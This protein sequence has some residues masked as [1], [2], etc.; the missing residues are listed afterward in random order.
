MGKPQRRLR[1]FDDADDGAG[2]RPS[3]HLEI[4]SETK[5][6]IFI[7]VVFAVAALSVLALFGQSGGFFVG[8][9]DLLGLLMGS[10]KF[11]F[12]IILA[13]WAYIMLRDDKYRIKAIN[14]FGAVLLVLGLT[15]MWHLKFGIWELFDRANEGLGGGWLG[16]VLS[17]P[18]LRYMNFWGGMVVALAVFLIGL[19]LS[20]EMSIHGLMWPVRF[21]KWIAATVKRYQAWAKERKEG[22]ELKQFEAAQDEGEEV[23]EEEFDPALAEAEVEDEA[24]EED[25]GEEADEPVFM[26][27]AL[28][29]AAA[30]PAEQAEEIY[31]P[32]K[33]GK[34]IVLPVNLV[35]AKAGKPTSGD[36]KNNQEIIK[37]TL[38]N[39]GIPVEMGLVNVGP[40]VTQYTLRPADGVKLSRIT[41][42]NSDLALALSAHPIRIE[43]PIPGKPLV[44][45]ELPNQMAAKVTMGEL[46]TSKEYKEKPSN[47]S[48]AL[49][50]DVSGKSYFASLDRMPHLLIAGSTGS[51][52]SVCVNSI[53]VSLLY[54]N[55][56][57]ELKFIMV[58]PKRVEL[59][60]YN[61]IP[62]LLTPVITDVKKTVQALKWAVVEMEKRFEMLAKVGKRNIGAYN[63]TAAP[64][65]KLPY[66]VFIID[67]LAD[68]MAS[69]SAD[70]EG[71]IVRLAQMARAVGI[72]LILAT[73]RPSIEVITGL[74]KANIPA[75][76]SF[77]VASLIDSRTILDTSGAEK[78]VGR[79]D[80]LYLGPEV[81]RP[82]RI[83]G[84]Y[85]SDKEISNVINYIKQFGEAD[86]IQEIGDKAA[87]GGMGGG[88]FGDDDGDSLLGEAK[89][90]IVQSGKASA[91]LL[92]RRLKVGYARAARIL[93]LLEDQGVIGPADGAKPREVFL[94][95]ISAAASP[96]AFAAREHGLEGELKPFI[97]DEA[98]EEPSFTAFSRDVDESDDATDEAENGDDDDDI[99]GD[100]D[101]IVGNE[102]GE[103]SGITEDDVDDDEE[104]SDGD[105]SDDEGEVQ[106]DD[107]TD[108][109]NV[110]DELED[111]AE[112][113]AEE[114][115]FEGE[116]TEA[117]DG[118]QDDEVTDENKETEA[119]DEA[120]E[121]E[122]EE[123]TIRNKPSVNKPKAVRGGFFDEGEWS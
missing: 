98:D 33:F 22:R 70:I 48:I 12:P 1:S 85:L 117:D 64:G 87:A 79:G 95:K 30:G 105:L 121:D 16:V 89:E 11:L 94:D 17:W 109:E 118:V 9:K 96:V 83:Q 23:E 10:L 57:D 27:K 115:D 122:E 78:L 50:K 38:G 18:L 104:N 120:E 77:A 102:A 71:G 39:F 32:K 44:G 51:G 58:D 108:E 28:A 29:E 34:K 53:I 80:M 65:D 107:S 81:S 25:E 101:N 14:Y 114:A 42:L 60:V 100:G 54:Q 74:I 13:V 123:V 110:D 20:F 93:D 45:I 61:K 2:S 119:Y 6:G 72:H 52:K 24:Q 3:G 90:I 99:D 46:L 66:I 5:K 92:Q 111:E 75:R 56:P 19:L 55:S 4:S 26:K 76:I 8:L 31:K 86:Y 43:A 116:E 37:K 82:K 103:G 97:D 112:E 59:T 36:I 49:G 63:E 15:A 21:F 69:A 106:G 41:N 47:L 67:E 68:L 7:I 84:V 88:G 73:Q 113:E 62:Y 91:S 35:A 40:T